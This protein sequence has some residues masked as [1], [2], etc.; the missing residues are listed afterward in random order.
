L[1]PKRPL[2]VKAFPLKMVKF[3]SG[4]VKR[5]RFAVR[6]PSKDLLSESLV[7]SAEWHLS[8]AEWYNGEVL[9]IAR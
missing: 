2:R 5:D 4:N 3:L 9:K 8:D 6:I 7:S 1:W